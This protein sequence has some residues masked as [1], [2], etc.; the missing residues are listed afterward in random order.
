MTKEASTYFQRALE[1]ADEES[2]GG[3]YAK[4]RSR[5][6]ITGTPSAPLPAPEWSR[7]VVG[8]EPALGENVH[9]V[10]DLGMPHN[11]GTPD[12]RLRSEAS[13]QAPT[14]APSRPAPATAASSPA[15]A[16]ETTEGVSLSKDQSR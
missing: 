11:E 8:I 5:P 10:P 6:A 7:D 3:R 13:P 14:D 12:W 9:A 15:N 2:G 4:Q 16:V 1:S